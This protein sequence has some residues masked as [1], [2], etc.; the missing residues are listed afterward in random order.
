M[1]GGA[2]T[3][4]MLE[5]R[6]MQLRQGEVLVRFFSAYWVRTLPSEQRGGTARVEAPRRRRVR[7]AAAV[8]AAA[9]R[10]AAA[11]DHRADLR[12]G[13][14]P[15]A[16]GAPRCGRDCGR[17]VA[18]APARRRRGRRAT[19]TPRYRSWRRCVERR[20]SRRSAVPL[21]SSSLPSHACSASAARSTSSPASSPTTGRSATAWRSCARRGEASC[22]RGSSL[23]RSLRSRARRS[24]IHGAT[25]PRRALP[26]AARVETGR[27]HGRGGGASRGRP[28]TLCAGAGDARRPRGG[29]GR[30]A[31]R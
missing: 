6:V 18:E 12:A 8:A 15:H 11:G 4:A 23:A 2:P 7:V 31:D 27:K 10:L 5:S 30:A 9:H 26:R 13:V 17:D 22:A 1:V 14:G 24:R 16:A 21:Q 25:P 28:L 19:T 3:A 20:A 29:R